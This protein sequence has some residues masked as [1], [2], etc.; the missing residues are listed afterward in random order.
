MQR[1][2]NINAL[3]AFV[4]VVKEGSVSAAAD[5]MNLTQPAISHQLKRLSAETDV[6]LFKRTSSGLQ[7]T[8]DGA[9]LVA[10]AERVIEAATDFHRSAHKRAGRISG[11][12]RI[13]TIVDP[14]FIRLG[15]MLH[16][17]RN[18][19]PDIET[20]L[21]HGVS[22]E[23]LSRL[24]R[25]QID[26]GFYLSG[27]DEFENTQSD[28]EEPIHALRLA[29]FNYRIIGPT[30]WQKQ[31]ETAS[32]IELAALPWIGTP[33]VSVHHRLLKPIFATHDVVQNIVARVDQEA[34]M[35]EMVRSGIGLSLCRDSIALSQ[36]Q[37]SGL[38]LC[39]EIHVPATLSFI[40]L[41]QRKDDITTSVLF[42]SVG[43]IW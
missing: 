40:T 31:L 22:G 14:A 19:Y 26:A 37:S 3:L 10:K 13:G 43:R 16:H 25:N 42:K 4:T 15:Q 18:D 28:Q 12:L 1:F 32:W 30:G 34:S 2:S 7:L 5:A 27:P 21:I 6:V 20:E 36:K 39:P 41:A 35:L 11:K 23:T 33:E 8:Q 24:R 17:M 38:A 29:D 9:N